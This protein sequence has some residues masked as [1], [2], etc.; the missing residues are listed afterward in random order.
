MIPEQPWTSIPFFGPSVF[1][2]VRR[3]TAESDAESSKKN[4]EEAKFVKHLIETIMR[5][6]PKRNSEWQAKI[7]IIVPYSGQARLIKE[8][9]RT[10]E[11]FRGHLSETDECPFEVSTIDGFQGREREVTLVFI[12]R[13]F[14]HCF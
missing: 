11:A 3:G 12:G 13:S 9:L 4:E 8:K 6:Y 5:L 10:L 7:G 2:D 14:S 1:F